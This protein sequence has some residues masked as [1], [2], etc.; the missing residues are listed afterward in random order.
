MK[1]VRWIAM[2]GICCLSVSTFGG[3]DLPESR[4]AAAPTNGGSMDQDELRNYIKNTRMAEPAS[5]LDLPQGWAIH[6]PPD[7][8]TIGKVTWAK[9]DPRPGYNS[10]CVAWLAG[11]RYLAIRPELLG[12]I[13]GERP[14][15]LKGYAR[16][17][18]GGKGYL[19]VRCLNGVGKVIKED[20]S[21][22]VENAKDYETL[23][24]EF[25]THPDTKD[26]QVYCVNGGA[27]KVWFHWVTLEPNLEKARKAAAFPFTV[28]CE[29]AEGNRF[30]NN[31]RAVLNSFQDS[32]TPASFAFWGDKSRLANP[33][34]VIEVPEGLAIPE[35]FNMEPRPPVSHAKAEFVTEKILRGK[36]PYVRHTFTGPAALQ[37]MDATPYLYCCLT[38]CFIPQTPAQVKEY[39]IFYHAEN[40]GASSAKRQVTVRI[41]SPMARTPNPKRFRAILWNL[42]DINFYDMGL[43]EQVI[44]KFE[45]A[46]LT[47]REFFSAGRKEINDVDQFLKKRGWL[48]FHKAS[49]EAFQQS[50]FP[51]IGGDGTP[52]KDSRMPY[53]PSYVVTNEEFFQKQLVSGT[54]KM[55]RESYGNSTIEDNEAVFLD[56]E[57]GSVNTKYCFC[58]RCRKLFAEKFNIPLDKVQ[59]RRDIMMN[60]HKEWGQ[61]W[62]WLCDEIIRLHVRAVKT[63]N[64]TL[65]NYF[66]C[67]AL[68]FDKPEATE[69]HLFESPLDTRMI[70][71][72]MDVLGLSF[73]NIRGKQ[74][75][76]VLA[77][78]TQTLKKPVYMMPAMFGAGPFI[79]AWGPYL[80]EQILSPAAMRLA[81]LTAAACGAAGVLPYEGKLMDGMYFLSIDQAMSEIAA[82]EEFYMDGRRKDEAIRCEGLKEF[83]GAAGKPL[84]QSN[85]ESTIGVRAHEFKGRLLVT[86][87]NFNE[88]KDAAV[89]L[90]IN[91]LGPNQ[92]N[93]KRGL[94]REPFTTPDGRSSLTGAELA[95]G[96]SCRVPAQD[97]LFLLVTPP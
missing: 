39:E 49:D 13:Q 17:E 18:A 74:A 25:S 75:L 97:V 14:F 66:Y 59:T 64:P 35:A 93:L 8:E 41:L 28:S 90:K 79:S 94:T 40:G 11:G 61:F 4:D 63:I 45:E 6:N 46:G 7:T 19:L 15:V 87:F 85:W 88:D 73:Y 30:W 51:A 70:Q 21:K 60:Y 50:P 69:A 86:V 20:A 57:P 54:E 23:S 68:P 65:K 31:G 38:M 32:P 83:P 84:L 81:V 55:L 9:D 37:R 1:A 34:L 16:T 71:K 36:T 67:Y 78:N 12:R 33:R 92:W 27:G 80:E 95:A 52:S 42:D 77:V 58:D 62:C 29:P 26:V 53:C 10:L 43:V 24:L 48:V 82:L 72:H 3:P 91:G 22:P 96:M 5:D 44:R 89:L 2:L 47:G 56:F 76:D